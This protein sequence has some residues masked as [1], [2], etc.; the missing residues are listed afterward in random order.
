[1]NMIFF[2][3]AIYGPYALVIY[4]HFFWC[5]NALTTSCPQAAVVVLN[6]L[7]GGVLYQISGR[8]SKTSRVV[9]VPKV[10]GRST[11]YTE[12]RIPSQRIH[13]TGRMV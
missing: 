2:V 12:L 5:N 8:A 1:M 10:G 4:F 3:E 9:E 6:R 7:S 13:A 11:T